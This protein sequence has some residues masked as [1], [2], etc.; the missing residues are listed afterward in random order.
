MTMKSS[1]I[2]FYFARKIYIADR[3]YFQFLKVEGVGV[4]MMRVGDQQ[5]SYFLNLLNNITVL[6]DFSGLKSCRTL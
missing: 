3:T 4:G 2:I 1:G 5:S 6:S